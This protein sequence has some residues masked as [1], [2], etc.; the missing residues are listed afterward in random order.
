MQVNPLCELGQRRRILGTLDKLLYIIAV[1]QLKRTGELAV[2]RV[3]HDDIEHRAA[4][5]YQQIELLLHLLPRV[6]TGYC[7]TKSLWSTL[8]QISAG[9]SENLMATGSQQ[10]DI[11]DDDLAADTHLG[12]QMGGGE[13]CLCGLKTGKNLAAPLFCVHDKTS[14]CMVFEKIHFNI[15]ELLGEIHIIGVGIIEAFHL[16]PERIHLC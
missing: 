7:F 1:V 6:H 5:V 8:Q 11:S 13:R 2:D 3:L 15:V 16:I 14:L 9:C 10:R 4:V 12:C